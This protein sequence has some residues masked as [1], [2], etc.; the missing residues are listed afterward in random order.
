[1]P[2]S[3]RKRRIGPLAFAALLLLLPSLALSRRYDPPEWEVI[4]NADAL[5]MGGAFSAVAEG[6]TAVRWNPAS[7]AFQPGAA[8]DVMPYARPTPIFEDIWFAS[9]AGSIDFGAVGVGANL[10]YLE[11]DDIRTVFGNGEP[12][13]AFDLSFVGVLLG[14]GVDLLDV[15]GSGGV[16]HPVHIGL[17]GT[18]KYHVADDY[19]SESPG[20]LY[21]SEHAWDLDFGSLV[22][23]DQVVGESA[24]QWSGAWTVK[25]VLDRKV[26]PYDG[27]VTRV[28]RLGLAATVWT[29]SFRS[30]PYLVR[31]RLVGDISGI[32]VTP[33]D[34]DSTVYNL[35]AELG[36]FGIA[37]LRIGWASDSHGDF[38]RASFGARLGNEFPIGTSGDLL[39]TFG[40][41][42]DF[43]SVPSPFF[44]ERAEYFTLAVRTGFY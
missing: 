11:F 16:H 7:L 42:V 8:L 33:D 36:A 10:N 40:V 37:A 14:A 4:P 35:G 41:R 17:G 43:A 25:N 6:P 12:R 9:A 19:F 2:N 23:V 13:G 24:V 18:F 20:D 1:M 28:D 22:R 15:M 26:E 32:L 38:H 30:F 3:M 21:E 39:H 44:D 5:G 27:R 29:G 34:W 31:G